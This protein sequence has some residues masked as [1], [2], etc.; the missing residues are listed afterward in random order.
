MIRLCLVFAFVLLVACSKVKTYQPDF[1]KPEGAV[2]ALEDAY[3]SKDLEAVVAA[4]DFH[5]DAFYFLGLQFGS[6]LG[7]T[8]Q[9][10]DALEANFRRQMTEEGF[11]D[12]AGVNSIF[13]KKAVLSPDQVI[14]T[15]RCERG[16]ATQELRLLVVKTARGWRTVLAPGFDTK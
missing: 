1:S 16:R 2:L 15:E 13:L 3:K 12:Y 7:K 11:P 8:N 9:M 5:Q 10:A 6:D 14:L 4:K